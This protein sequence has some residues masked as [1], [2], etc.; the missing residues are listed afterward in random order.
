MAAISSFYNLWPK[1]AEAQWKLQ[2]VMYMPNS[3]TGQNMPYKVSLL[4]DVEK[5][6]E[7]LDILGK[8]ADIKQPWLIAH[9]DKDTSVLL[10]HAEELHRAQ[11]NA[12]LVVF[13]GADHV[14]NSTHP[15]LEN[16][17]P[18]MLL[19]FCDATIAFLGK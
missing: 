14:F 5:N 10:S 2:G 18:A 3:R 11:P 15:Y 7:R 8:A 12:K 16:A 1:Q 17:L 19:K 9:G 13:E 4:Y 6:A